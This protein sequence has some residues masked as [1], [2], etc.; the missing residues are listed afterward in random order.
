MKLIIENWRNF[1]K[2]DKQGVYSFDYDYTLIK[3]YQDPEDKFNIIYDEPHYENI[4]KLKKLAAS[5]NKIFIVTSRI[6]KP[7]KSDWDTA[8][9]PEE[10]VSELNLPISGIYYTNGELKVDILLKLGV[11][12]H[13]D[14]DPEEVKAAEAQ[15]IK[16]HLVP[17]NE[18]EKKQLQSFVTKKLNEEEIEIPKRMKKHLKNHPYMEP[19][20]LQDL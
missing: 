12:E 14:D 18:N 2:E 7:K 6:K 10:L 16:T 5:G 1:L 8:P 20:G 4:Q 17:S 19:N 9:W 11:T 3:Y 13:W 15:G